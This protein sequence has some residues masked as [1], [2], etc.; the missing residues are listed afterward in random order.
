MKSRTVQRLFLTALIVAGCFAAGFQVHRIGLHREV[1]YLLN[2]IVN[3]AW[4]ASIPVPHYVR[5]EQCACVE[6]LRSC[7]CGVRGQEQIYEVS[8]WKQFL[9]LDPEFKY[10]INPAFPA[11]LREAVGY[12]NILPRH[13]NGGAKIDQIATS[14]FDGDGALKDLRLSYTYPALS[15][16]ALLATHSKTSKELVIVLHGIASS[17]DAVMGLREEDYMG[18]VGRTLFN[19][20]YDVMAPSVTSNT[21]AAGAMNMSLQLLGS[22]IYGLW[23]RL[24]CDAAQ[25][26]RQKNGY[27]RIVLYGLSNGGIITK[28]AT[29]LCN[30]FDLSIVD[31]VGLN[32]REGAWNSTAKVENS[33]WSFLVQ[34]RR[35]LLAESSVVDWLHFAKN[36]FIYIGR[37]NILRKRLPR[38][39]SYEYVQAPGFVPLSNIHFVQ[40]RSGLH[41]PEHDLLTAILKEN[42]SGLEGYSLIPRKPN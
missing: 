5:F 42:W 26:F 3:V 1:I 34:Y 37:K 20:G 4:P 13:D 38:M 14:A 11:L 27:E 31:D 8:L 21:V 2:R 23:S 19:Q 22:Q 16:R 32:E 24:V 9:D 10:R 7:P 6:Y 40:K 39:T 33:K 12:D 41:T 18:S 25:F 30:Q 36:K 15:L 17:E 35:P 28:H 29:A